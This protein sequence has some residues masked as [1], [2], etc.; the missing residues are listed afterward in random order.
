MRNKL[1]FLI[2]LLFC[3]CNSIQEEK[4]VIKTGSR[5]L[6]DSILPV[7]TISVN[8]IKDSLQSSDTSFKRMSYKKDFEFKFKDFETFYLQFIKDSAFQL[9]RVR[10][11]LKGQYED[12]DNQR[13]WTKLNWPYLRW[14]MRDQ[15]NQEDSTSVIQTDL[16]FFYGTYCLDCG[17]SFEMEFNKLNGKWFLTYRQENNF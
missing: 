8:R 6:K 7:D 9:S 15:N 12:Y 17:F 2:M 4:Q 5:E 1:W 10:F 3:S 13:N 16:R 11:P 14:D